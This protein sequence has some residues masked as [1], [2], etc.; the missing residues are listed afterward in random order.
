MTELAGVVGESPTFRSVCREIARLANRAPE[1]HR[2]PPVLIQGETGTGKGLFARAMHQAGPRRGGPFVDVNCAAIPETLLES[3]MFGFE[4]GTFTDARQAKPGLFETAHGGTLFLD[5]LGYLPL[6]LQTKLLK[7][8]EERSVRRL[9]S[10]RNIAVDVSIVSATAED[11]QTLVRAG[12]FRPELYHRVAVFTLRLPPLRERGGDVLLL[13]EHFLAATCADYRL[14]QKRFADDA[15]RALTAYSWPGNVRELGNVVERAALLSDVPLIS[16]PDLDLPALMSGRAAAATD[17]RPEEEPPPTPERAGLLEALEATGW[18]LSR[19]AARL[20]IPRNTL[21]YRMERHGLREPPPS[22][23][24]HVTRAREPAAAADSARMPA[25]SV[26]TLPL[27]VHRETRPIAALGAVVAAPPPQVSQILGMIA[28][29]VAM[30]GGMVEEV[31]EGHMLAVFGRDTAEQAPRR[32]ALAASAVRRALATGGASDAAVTQAIHVR[33][34][35]V[36]VVGETIA[37]DEDSRRDLFGTVR[38]LLGT[39]APSAVVAS[40]AGATLLE[41]WFDIVPAADAQFTGGV[42]E[43]TGPAR[44][45]FGVRGR[46]TPF[47]G[48]SVE[49]E[50]LA[51]RLA[52]ARD[53]AG[54]VV[55]IVGD[56]GLGKSRLVA[57]LCESAVGRDTA[58]LDGRCFSYAT[59][60]PYLPVATILRQLCV[61]AET[62]GPAAIA[63]G[64]AATL[65]AFDIE[66]RSAPYLVEL[67]GVPGHIAGVSPEMV[68][69][70]T[71]EAVCTL[72]LQASRQRPFV[73]VIEDAHWIDQTSDE[74]LTALVD[75]IARARLLLVLTYRPGYRP[76]W[77]GKSYAAQLTLQ[78]LS[79]DESREIVRWSLPTHAVTS[80]VVDGI[81]MRGEGNPFFLEELSRAVEDGTNAAGALAVPGTVHD[82]LAGRMAKLDAGDRRLLQ[83]AAVVGKDVEYAVLRAIA[84]V[85]DDVLGSRL[86]LLQRAEFLTATSVGANPEYTFKH[87]LTHD[88]AY[89]SLLPEHRRTLHGQIVEAIERLYPER[90]TEQVERL[91]HHAMRGEVWDKAVLY[92]E[93]AAAKAM[94]RSALREVVA[95]C[96]QALVALR[97]LPDNREALERAI[98]LRFDPLRYALWQLGEHARVLDHLREAAALAETRTD[99]RRLGWALAYMANGLWAMENYEDAIVSGRRALAIASTLEDFA[100]RMRS[101][102]SLAQA[103]HAL[104]SFRPAIDLLESNMESLQGELLYARFGQAGLLSVLS[105]SYLVLSL[106]ELGEFTEAIR[107]AEQSTRIA[108]AVDRPYELLCAYR[109]TG[110]VRLRKGDLHGAVSMLER[111]QSI[112]QIVP[113]WSSLIA[114][115]LGYAY[116]LS[117]RIPDAFPFLERA[118][119]QSTSKGLLGGHS[120]WITFLSEAHLLAGHIEDAM[121]LAHR[122]LDLA[123]D[124]KER[125]HQAWAL[126]L[127]GEIAARRDPHETEHAEPWYRRALA[128]VEELGMRPLIAH[129]HLGLG[130]LYR[131]TGK[132][133]QARGDLTTATTMYREMDMRFWLEKAETEMK[134]SA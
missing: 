5:E 79:R 84:D 121:E 119:E 109:A 105:L 66:P 122:G 14:G 7:V 21:R 2:M 39:A 96:E 57:E 53:G 117:G 90:L 70:R 67:L 95:S 31:G 118:L 40:Q 134:G 80:A 37:I 103:Y 115:N 49:R 81:L 114:S 16:A 78:R 33:D 25:A 100:L 83:T 18:N 1:G 35:L 82:V 113:G 9:G 89:G 45:P 44:A 94:T 48:R 10:T 24:L 46:V 69:T 64:V 91:A 15:R 62:D 107:Y 97:H 51:T 61:I 12:R 50:W 38:S 55:G 93:Q 76:A 108:E 92:S 19:A 99:Q 126:R 30:F 8:I 29:K 129:C 11:L 32:A 56:A 22:R 43:L 116:A 23:R 3:E 71:F 98:D 42:Y 112:S 65:T 58:R 120:L 111:S 52:A 73:V 106:A 47:V 26:A 54:Q 127:I 102:L 60:T 85:P 86:R 68:K 133:D 20:R 28:E 124:R 17:E 41:R 34:S 36:G 27:T 131:C 75:S 74:L 13:A 130:K 128:L 88:V 6:P 132:Q 125:G 4:R 63:A 59:T 101:H 110:L 77:L 104:G 72:V 87:A 123:S